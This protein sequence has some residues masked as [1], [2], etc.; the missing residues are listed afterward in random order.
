MPRVYLRWT[1]EELSYLRDS[2]GH[3]SPEELVANLRGRH[4][5]AIAKKA[6][7]LGV[8]HQGFAHK[9]ADLSILLHDN[10][11]SY[12]WMGFLMADGG[13]TTRRLSLGVATKDLDHLRR[14]L[15]FVNSTNHILPISETY[16]RVT[17]ANVKVIGQLREK[18]GI[19]SRK[20][21]EPCL[22]QA[23]PP[24]DLLF[25]L[26]VGFIDGDGSVVANKQFH[27][28]LLS[29]VGHSSWLNNFAFMKRFLYSHFGIE[30][31]YSDAYLRKCKVQL[32]QRR[33][34]TQHTMA[35]FYIG[36][37]PLLIQ[38]REH[39]EKLGLPY[40]KRKLGKI[41]ELDSRVNRTA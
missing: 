34:K 25:S 28:F 32:P 8:T 4:Y 33:C 5:T 12:Y 27:S 3:V 19:T 16:H 14:F 13:F 30:R 18:F 21:Y 26:V 41:T 22:L 6:Q 20:T 11:I 29:V 40:L 31:S 2:Y 36:Y 9:K 7:V 10:P 15:S 1:K 17:I 35:Y 38:I 24:N 39:A 23:L 37:L